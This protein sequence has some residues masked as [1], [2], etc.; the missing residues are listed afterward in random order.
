M[1]E[2]PSTETLLK[3]LDFGT[4]LGDQSTAERLLRGLLAFSHSD[5]THG[6]ASQI[7]SE[8]PDGISQTLLEDA[9]GYM[10]ASGWIDTQFVNGEIRYE[11]RAEDVIEPL[12]GARRMLALSRE[13]E[14]RCEPEEF[15]L[16]CT[17]PEE[18]PQF[19]YLHPVDFGLEQITSRLLEL[20]GR[21][22]CR[23]V[24][25]SPFIESEGVEWLIPGLRSAIQ[26]GVSIDFISKDLEMGSPNSHALDSLI[27][28]D[29]G[30]T[31]GSLRIFDYYEPPEDREVYPLYTLHCKLLLVDG[32]RAYI[33][34]ANF[35]E[36]AFS[37]YLEVGTILEGTQVAGLVD[38][39]DH[40]LTGNAQQIY[41]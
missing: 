20:C 27:N 10:E 2:E 32:E 17:L 1:T 3:Q 35:T 30:Q 19:E 11:I 34:S 23:I 12:V 16:L 40:V 5:R 8:V 15:E 28:A 4:L 22:S 14:D 31:P 25:L 7:F 9:L 38:L 36:N 26:R 39:A 29:Q 13:M 41:P 18:D 21:A 37:R 24:L 6:S 33:G